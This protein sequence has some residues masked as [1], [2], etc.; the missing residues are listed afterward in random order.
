MI[1]ANA[2]RNPKTREQ[3]DAAL[4]LATIDSLATAFTADGREI[5]TATYDPKAVP[6]FRFYKSGVDV[7]TDVYTALRSLHSEDKAC[8]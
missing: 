8:A 2:W 5:F 3:I 1:N 7:T 4:R 6:A